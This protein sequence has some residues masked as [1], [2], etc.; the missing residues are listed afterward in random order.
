[1][2]RKR[3]YL[4]K[5]IGAAL[6][7][8]DVRLIRNETLSTAAKYSRLKRSAQRAQMPQAFRS[9]GRRIRRCLMSLRFR[10]AAA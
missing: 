9:P 2:M 5:E 6:G 1:A 8:A 3:G 10:S 4:L 7:K